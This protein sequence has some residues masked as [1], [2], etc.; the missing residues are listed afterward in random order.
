MRYIAIA[1]VA[2][3]VAMPVSAQQAVDQAA[4]AQIET[5]ATAAPAPSADVPAT[6]APAQRQL[7]R[8]EVVQPRFNDASNI[9]MAMAAQVDTRTRNILAVIGAVVV[10][11]AVI[12][13]VT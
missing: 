8:L 9:D 12:A 6:V 1:F 7:E 11:L 10:V 13:F 3:L 5:G 2:A 4:A